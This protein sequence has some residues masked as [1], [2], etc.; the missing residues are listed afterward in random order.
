VF[1]SREDLWRNHVFEIF[2]DWVNQTLSQTEFISIHGF[3]GG[4]WAKLLKN[5][6][7]FIP[8]DEQA[9]ALIPVRK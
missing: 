2:L 5:E 6:S 4:W 1:L 3:T 8:S 7:S 9:Y